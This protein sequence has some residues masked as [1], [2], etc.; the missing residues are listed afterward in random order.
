MLQQSCELSQDYCS[1]HLFYFIAHET[2]VLN[3]LPALSQVTHVFV[4]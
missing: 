2:R 3:I 1:T 4:T